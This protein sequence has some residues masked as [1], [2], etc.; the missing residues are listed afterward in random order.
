[1]IT[2]IVAFVF[3]FGLL[4]I[5]HEY[6]HYW[7]AKRAGVRV[8]TFSIGFGPKLLKWSRGGTEF[9]LSAIPLGGYVK[10]H[11]ESEG[12]EIAKEDQ[13][14]FSNKSVKARSGIVL[15]G[16]FMNLILSFVLIPLAFLVGKK[17]PDYYAKAPIVERVVM[18]S[19]AEK[20]GF[21]VGDRI[22]L[23]NPESSTWRAFETPTWKAF[24]LAVSESPAGEALAV[25][26]RRGEN[27]LTLKPVPETMPRGKISFI[28]VE[29]YFGASPPAVIE[30]VFPDSPAEKAG[31]VKGDRI[32]GVDGGQV[33]TWEDFLKAMKTQG[34]GK[35]LLKIRRGET[36]ETAA[37]EPEYHSESGR[38]LIGIQGPPGEQI[39]LL[40]ILL[41][42]RDIGPAEAAWEGLKIGWRNLVLTFSVIKRLV[43]G[44]ESYKQLGGPVAI[45]Y[46]L[47][48]AAS[49]GLSDFLF[50]TSFLSLQ[51][52]I[53]NLLPIPV[54]DGGHLVFFGIEALRRKPLDLKARL[55]ATQIGMIL[56][57]SLILLVTWNDLKRFIG[58]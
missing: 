6:G 17:D 12:E 18:D 14:A 2:S 54:L 8:E 34:A 10:M 22:L 41:T 58:F 47:A 42:T 19:P 15:A 7:M 30:K 3:A 25:S 13:E 28:G 38:F 5:I 29:K 9:C 1:M 33:E 49:E 50:F 44:Q 52:G 26:V 56:L 48:D 46:I 43:A 21:E 37:V 27:T 35:I 55:V 39:N 24:I 20:A 51:L 4:V 45:A 57:L 31:I 36:T 16:P 53:L 23:V 40:T 11:G 32:A